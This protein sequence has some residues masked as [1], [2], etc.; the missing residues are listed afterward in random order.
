MVFKKSTDL[1]KNVAALRYFLSRLLFFLLNSN[2]DLKG[3][4]NAKSKGGKEKY[5]SSSATVK[6]DKYASRKNASM[7]TSR[8]EGKNSIITT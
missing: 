6:K 2:L 5:P 7:Y 4:L 8:K 3:H 1:S